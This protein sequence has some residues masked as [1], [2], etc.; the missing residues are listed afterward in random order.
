MQKP[1][2]NRRG[3]P[4]EISDAMNTAITSASGP[5]FLQEHGQ[6]LSCREGSRKILCIQRKIGGDNTNNRQTQRNAKL[7]AFL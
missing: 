5:A 7:P 6:T 4:Q 2:N 1:R 3:F